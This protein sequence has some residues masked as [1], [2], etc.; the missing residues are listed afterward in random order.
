MSD[1]SYMKLEKFDGSTDI[2]RWLNELD[3]CIKLKGLK[4]NDAASFTYYHVKGTA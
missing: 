2:V 4:E 1:F 3:E